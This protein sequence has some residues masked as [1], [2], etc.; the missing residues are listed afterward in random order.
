MILSVLIKRL[1]CAL[2]R[3]IFEHLDNDL[4]QS[5]KQLLNSYAVQNQ[6]KN[7]FIRITG[8]Q[9]SNAKRL[10]KAFMIEKRDVLQCI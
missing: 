10:Y 7:T 6:R 3:A 2:K 8:Q 4:K 1:K 5:L 9:I